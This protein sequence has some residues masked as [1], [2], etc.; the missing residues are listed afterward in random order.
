ME[1][2]EVR[3]VREVKDDS[4]AARNFADKANDGNDKGNV[5]NFRSNDGNDK[6]NVCN[7]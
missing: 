7:F 4:L 6:G 5:C 2:K 1:V 3:E